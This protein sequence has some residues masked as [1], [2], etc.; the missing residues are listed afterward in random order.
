MSSFF[1][2]VLEQEIDS[3]NDH[4]PRKRI[5]LKDIVDSEVFEYETRGGEFSAFRREEIERLTSIVPSRLYSEVRLPIVILRR[6][7]LGR[8]IHTISGGK[9]EL[10]LVNGL[11]VGDVDLRW[12]EIGSWEPNERLA[13]PQVQVLRRKLPSTTC[14]GFT[15]AVDGENSSSLTNN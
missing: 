15:T 1:D 11:I 2:K 10:F 3:V 14:M 4:L 5:S 12:D 13:R 7:D 6:M 9:V 8:G